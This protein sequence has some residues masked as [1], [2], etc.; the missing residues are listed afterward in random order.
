MTKSTRRKFI[1]RASLGLSAISCSSLLPHR[2]LASDKA[3]APATS[4]SE[5]AGLG[6]FLAS[7]RAEGSIAY[8]WRP[9]GAEPFDKAED[10]KRFQVLKG[11][12]E[13]GNGQLKATGGLGGIILLAPNLAGAERVEFDATLLPRPDG[14]ICNI[15][16]FF[17]AVP[18]S[19]GSSS[20]GE[21]Y[22][23]VT[24]QYWNQATA[25]YRK[26]TPIARTEWSPIVPGQ[27]HHMAG[28]WTPEGHLRYFVDGRIV[29]DA[30][31]RI[32]PLIPDPA[33]WIGL[34]VYETD[35]IVENFIISSGTRISKAHPATPRD[36]KPNAPIQR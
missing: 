6:Q 12:W 15:G 29:L 23:L 18:S 2:V 4:A 32:E 7:S 8:E 17:N 1:Q 31:D 26:G 5:D 27:R 36:A 16:L 11:N 20:Y 25:C 35:M 34:W 24:A 30:W 21:G 14:R 19:K 10:I 3:N 33:K 22:A 28:E 13:V 9:V